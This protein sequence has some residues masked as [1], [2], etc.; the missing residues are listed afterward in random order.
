MLQGR[1]GRGRGVQSAG[2]GGVLAGL[3][4][5]LAAQPQDLLVA[6]GPTWCGGA[7]LGEVGVPLSR[8]CSVSTAMVRRNMCGRALPGG[9]SSSPD[10]ARPAF[11]YDERL[12]HRGTPGQPQPNSGGGSV[13]R[14][15][16]RGRTPSIQSIVHDNVVEHYNSP[17]IASTLQKDHAGLPRKHW[18]ITEPVAEAIGV[19]DC[20]R[21]SV[22]STCDS[23]SWTSGR[24][25]HL[26]QPGLGLHATDDVGS[27]RPAADRPCMDSGSQTASSRGTGLYRRPRGA[28]R[29]YSP[30]WLARAARRRASAASARACFAARS[31][32]R[33]G[34]NSS[35]RK[36]TASRNLRPAGQRQQRAWQ[37]TTPGGTVRRAA[38]RRTAR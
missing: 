19:A 1:D 27:Q 9:I 37:R 3:L 31:A 34:Q 17:A 4:D 22:R 7:V 28:V 29:R 6:T 14:P 30:P 32:R 26:P 33:A 11:A 16:R 24:P 2:E 20:R 10:Q 15:A 8:D 23:A 21:S 38:S 12:H 18:W 36:S 35:V 13:R 5:E 25:H